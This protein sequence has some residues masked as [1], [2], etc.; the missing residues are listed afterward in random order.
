MSILLH[1]IQS[2][3]RLSDNEVI[4]ML[5]R[6][7]PTKAD[8][9]Q[10]CQASVVAATTHNN[11]HTVLGV[12]PARHNMVRDNHK[13]TV[14]LLPVPL[15][16]CAA[17]AR[18]ARLPLLSLPPDGVC[19]FLLCRRCCSSSLAQHVGLMLSHR[20]PLHPHVTLLWRQIVSTAAAG[21]IAAMPIAALPIAIAADAASYGPISLHCIC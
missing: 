5:H 20:V 13:V 15:T 10:E 19:S 3:I 18:D 9:P 12:P 4:K 7:P 1:N 16:T 21:A 11:S 14:L 6:Q 8:Q 2:T 17:I